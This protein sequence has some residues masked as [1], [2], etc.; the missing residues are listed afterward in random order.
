MITFSFVLLI[1]IAMAGD[2]VRVSELTT[3][4]VSLL[5]DRSIQ[6][7]RKATYISSFNSDW[8][9]WCGESVYY[10]LMQ[11]PFVDEFASW[12]GTVM[13]EMHD[14]YKRNG[15]VTFKVFNDWITPSSS[16]GRNLEVSTVSYH[17][18]D[19]TIQ[20]KKAAV[21]GCL[22]ACKVDIVYSFFGIDHI[23]KSRNIARIR[24][25]GYHL[26]LAGDEWKKVKNPPYAGQPYLIVGQRPQQSQLLTSLVDGAQDVDGDVWDP[27]AQFERLVHK[28]VSRVVEEKKVSVAIGEIARIVKDALRVA[29]GDLTGIIG[30][31]DAIENWMWD[32]QWKTAK[33]EEKALNY[34]RIG[35]KYHWFIAKYK[36]ENAV[37][38]YCL[39]GCGMYE[40]R[41]TVDYYEM[42]P[43]NRAAKAVIQKLMQIQAEQQVYGIAQKIQQSAGIQAVGPHAQVLHH[44]VAS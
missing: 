4:D 12:R 42:T 31:L 34:F 15:D 29:L 14:L 3:P 19:A 30:I 33:E 25:N 10:P 24:D 32:F 37:C 39:G 36:T 9:F 21:V 5:D 44:A 41:V 40:L 27:R 8:S 7:R 18:V 23:T 1:C 22:G 2:R 6:S 26:E 28:S 17:Y 38:N 43:I 35:D 20:F 16:V 13:Q 11:R